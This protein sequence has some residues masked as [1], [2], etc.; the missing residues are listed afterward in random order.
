MDP[1]TSADPADGTVGTGGSACSAG[2]PGLEPTSVTDS[3]MIKLTPADAFE[4]ILEA[5]LDKALG[6]TATS[7]AMTTSSVAAAGAS[8]AV[9]SGVV[10]PP[11]KA[12]GASRG[13]A[14]TELSGP[15]FTEALEDWARSI[16]VSPVMLALKETGLLGAALPVS[17]GRAD[18]E[19]GAAAPSGEGSTLPSECAGSGGED[20]ATG[21]SDEMTGGGDDCC[22]LGNDCCCWSGNDRRSND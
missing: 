19:T 1:L 12:L 18:W 8:L 3:G 17:D 11:G 5:S 16:P 13:A 6:A 21:D 9:A 10:E 2:C 7:P 20:E 14:S 4:V 15:P 22:W